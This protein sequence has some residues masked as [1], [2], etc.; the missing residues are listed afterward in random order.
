M[1]HA[2]SYI[3]FWRYYLCLKKRLYLLIR[4]NGYKT[5]DLAVLD[6]FKLV[7]MIEEDKF[8]SDE[9][10]KLRKFIEKKKVESVRLSKF[11]GG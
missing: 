9:M 1:Q 10:K 3:L 7:K 6:S 8:S 5:E 2:M 11:D 4:K